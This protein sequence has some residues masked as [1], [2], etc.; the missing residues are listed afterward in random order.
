[1]CINEQ[2]AGGFDGG[3][4]IIEGSDN[5]SGKKIEVDFS[6]ENLVAYYTNKTDCKETID[7]DNIK[8]DQVL[9]TT[10]DTIGS[11][12]NELLCISDLVHYM[13]AC[14]CIMPLHSINLHRTGLL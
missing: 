11:K 2:T 7:F 5:F 10:P 12:C 3:Y 1:M 6:N 8:E 14:L 13:F 9:V 4:F